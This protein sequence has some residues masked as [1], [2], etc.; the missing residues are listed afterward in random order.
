M[1]LLFE[2]V[3]VPDKEHQMNSTRLSVWQ[4]GEVLN[5]KRKENFL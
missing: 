2:R 3:Y 4:S 5:K 1:I